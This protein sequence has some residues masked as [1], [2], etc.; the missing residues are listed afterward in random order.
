M[1]IGSQTAL[2]NGAA[3]VIDSLA[4]IENDRTYTPLRFIAEKLGA[5]IAWNSETQEVIITK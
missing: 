3:L 1:D 4:F 5:D 2:L